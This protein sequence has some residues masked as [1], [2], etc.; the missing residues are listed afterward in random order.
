MA[1]YFYN[2]GKVHQ[3]ADLPEVLYGAMRGAALVLA[4]PA[5][6]RR[7]ESLPTLSVQVLTE[8]PRAN[9]LLQVDRR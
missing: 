1:G 9:S 3:I 5:E 8:G 6:R 4:G 2:D 7:L